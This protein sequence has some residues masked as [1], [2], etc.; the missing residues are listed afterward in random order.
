MEAW[1]Q[2]GTKKPDSDAGFRIY[3]GK[4]FWLSFSICYSPDSTL[5][6]GITDTK[7][8]SFLRLRNS[9]LP[10]IRAKRV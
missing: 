8:L 3:I 2:G 9:T 10:S 7:D 6:T 4:R 5:T 1:K